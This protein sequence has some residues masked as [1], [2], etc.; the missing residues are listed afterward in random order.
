MLR[1]TTLYASS[2]VATAA[3]YT[4]YLACAPGEAPGRWLGRQAEGLGLTGPVEADELQLLL[5]G[6]HPSDGTPL[7]SALIDRETAAGR[8]VRAVA[9]FDATFSAPKS[10]SVWWALTGDPG[11]LAAHDTAVT[12][13][14]GYLEW[15][16]ATT[17]IR[18]HG[19]R[20][21][22]DT[23]G[24]TMATF[25]Q[26]TSR[27]DDP[28]L[29]THAVISGK[30]QTADGRWRALDARFLKRH[31][32]TLGGLYQSVLRAELT[33][34]Y[35]ITWGPIAN[36]QAEI[37][38][39]PGELLEVFSKRTA[40]VDAALA[41]TIKQ[42]QTREGRDPTRWERAAMT[43]EAVADTRARKTGQPVAGLRERWR[44]EA[45][46]LGWTA[47]RLIEGLTVPAHEH[48]A[49][50]A[51]TVAQVLDQLSTVGS[52]W[53]RADVM[54]AVCDLTPPLPGMS[55]AQWAAALHRVTNEVLGQCVNLDPDGSGIRRGSDGR[56]V[57]LEPTSPH[58]TSPTVLAEEERILTWALDAQI[59][60][61]APSATVDRDGLDV[62]QGDAAAAVA[63]ADRLA[64]V[65]GPAGTGKTTM[66]RAAVN[67]LRRHGRTV[68]GVAPTAKAAHVLGSETGMEA[69]TVA[70]LLHEWSRRDRLPDRR[71]QLPV[72]TTLVVDES[73]MLG[74]SSLHH[75]TQLAQHLDWRLVLVGD[76]R[77]LQ[78]VG[79][80]GLFAELAATSR[81]HELVRI[82]RFT[83]PWEAASSLQLRAGD[84]DAL[85]GYETHGRIHAG[86]LEDHL[87]GIAQ[88]WLTATSAGRTVAI[89]ASSNQHV[90][91]LNNTIQQARLNAGDLDPVTAVPIA[92][93]ERAHGG[94]IVVTRRNDRQL[95]TS[96]GG[97]VRNR[98]QWLVIATHVDGA[99]TVERLDGRSDVT[100][101]TEYVAEHVRLGY[102][103]TEHGHQGDTVD[104]G[105]AFTSPATSHRGL[106]VATTRGRHDN[107]IHVITDTA[108][109]SEARE[110]LEGV[111]ALDCA[112]IPAV[113][114][115]R[116][117]A[118]SDSPQPTSRPESL[119]P[120]WLP[121]WRQQITERRQQLVDDLADHQKQRAA[122][123]QELNDLQPA[124]DAARRAWEPY[125]RPIDDL[126]RELDSVLRP[127]LWRANHEAR[128]A[129]L[130]HRR[131]AQRQ[132]ADAAEAVQEAEAA[133]A[134]IRADGAP[135]KQQLDRLR[136]REGELR[137]LTIG[138]DR[139]DVHLRQQIAELDQVLDATDTYTAWLDGRPIPSARLAHAVDTLTTVARH[140]YAFARHPG[141][142]DQVQ[143]YRLLDLASDHLTDRVVRQRSVDGLEL[144]R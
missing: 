111:L 35:D 56:S 2:A 62:L 3:Y 7:G 16:G 59:A 129:G 114:Q 24:L 77:Q 136:I 29:H 66:L 41:D 10:L 122:R 64:V 37:T 39:I 65:V 36:G 118:Q 113:T 22:P 46:T 125:A 142:I 19:R 78:A 94:E 116:H 63:G 134:A 138:P 81:T 105:I 117:L 86:R 13:A 75:L 97:T 26:T 98:D 120:D 67:D 135:Q 108:D 49:D 17:R 33:H 8:L 31:Q 34:R 11:L 1:V 72:G 121:T 61:P 23:L 102:A 43:R 60:D 90:D 103:A 141:E 79:R 109:P 115:R 137:S 55:G 76:P 68:F 6:R 51:V 100:L 21:H 80:G 38:G 110:I 58:Y 106:Y 112:D 104:I 9:G 99:L 144:G 25:R 57:W 85:D 88:D 139:P 18:S 92:G 84:S 12:A 44:D 20:L 40:Q 101:P 28:Q 52:T 126:Q 50:S 107:R 124:L 73:G 27:T 32:R 132:A 143:W 48:Q 96:S 130:G 91:A 74:T 127:D 15:Y 45:R 87:A 128:T 69:D 89:T 82:H 30:V 71:Y 54:R 4:R 14:L 42:F 93:G 123:R 131:R 133:I 119:A 47:Q 53:T 70:K 140:A 83:H 5:E 95:T